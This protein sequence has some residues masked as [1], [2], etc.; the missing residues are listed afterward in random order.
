MYFGEN[1]VLMINFEIGCRQL[2][3]RSFSSEIVLKTG[4]YN[5]L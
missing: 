3:E 2:M 5:N 1:L 4:V